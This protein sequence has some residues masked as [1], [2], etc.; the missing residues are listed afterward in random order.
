M[1]IFNFKIKNPYNNR[2]YKGFL[3]EYMDLNQGPPACKAGALNQLSYTPIELITMS[4][5]QDYNYITFKQY[6]QELIKNI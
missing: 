2:Y 1:G 4:K 5:N 6:L 3:W